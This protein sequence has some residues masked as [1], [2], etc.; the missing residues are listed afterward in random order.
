[1]N[2]L[3]INGPNINLLGVRE[4]EIYGNETFDDL[5]AYLKNYAS[6]T[7]DR[8]IFFQSNHEG[9][10]IDFIQKNY[11]VADG[12]V[13][14]PGAYSHYSYAIYDCLLS[15]PIQAVEVHLTNI[16]ERE[17]FRNLSVT[18]PACIATVI[19]KR[20]SG[21]AEAIEILRKRGSSK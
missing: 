10:I 17:R 1:M 7:G 11:T 16:H 15:V 19:G 13:I 5:L 6:G 9:A 21:Y 18:A 8:L 2:I 20:F 12:I 4:P 3:V 14:N